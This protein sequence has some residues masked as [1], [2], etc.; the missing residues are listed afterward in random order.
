MLALISPAK[1]MLSVAKASES[2]LTQPRFKEFA[3]YIVSLMV[4]YSA[5]ELAEMFKVSPSI[6]RELKM[7]F[8]ALADGDSN[9]CAAIDCYDGVVYKHIKQRGDM[10]AEE[11]DFLQAN[12]RISSLL[13]G[14]LR[15]LDAIMPYRMEGFVRLA[16]DDERVDRY[17]RDKQ[18][19]MLIDDVQ[20]QGGE[21]L[22]LA[23]AEEKQAFNWSQV[24]RSVRIIDF[25]F[26]QYK[27]DKL[28]QV[29]VYTKMA[30]GEMVRYIVDNR[31]TCP[32]EL[33]EFEWAGYRYDEF[34]STADSWV[35]V[36]D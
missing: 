17:W 29:V 1:S 24:K 10:N 30:R 25:K 13:Y 12:L 32:D 6:A 15:P 34:R 31:I 21:L 7:R 20:K 3:A 35:W 19:Q 9:C 11:R 27:G 14:L 28:R 8:L 26:L 33:K 4:G 36:M 18:T 5:G 23:S 16:G 2:I 22:Y